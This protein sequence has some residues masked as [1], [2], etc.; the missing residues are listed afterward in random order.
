M[1]RSIRPEKAA[2]PPDD[3][4]N[5]LQDAF[6]R[7]L[8]MMEQKLPDPRKS[9]AIGLLMVDMDIVIALD[10]EN[11]A[12]YDGLDQIMGDAK[13]FAEK[14]QE[15]YRADKIK[16]TTPDDTAARRVHQIHTLMIQKIIDYAGENGLEI[17]EPTQ[18]IKSAAGDMGRALGGD[19][20]PPLP[21]HN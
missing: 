12:N 15:W 9:K 7:L 8:R 21:P 4:G 14:M 2:S 11:T 3:S 1:I 6:L 5:S 20:S 13:F 19:D 18:A 16:V 10:P 17:K